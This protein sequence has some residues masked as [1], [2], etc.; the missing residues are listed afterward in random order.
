MMGKREDEKNEKTGA[1]GDGRLVMQAKTLRGMEKT[2][3]N[4]SGTMS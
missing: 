2:G 1:G 3:D 4:H